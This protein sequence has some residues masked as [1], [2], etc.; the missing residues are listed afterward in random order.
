M[1]LK[2]CKLV[3]VTLLTPITAFAHEFWIEPLSY[4][5][6]TGATVSAHLNVGQNFSG[7]TYSYIEDNFERFDLVDRNGA[8]TPV[9]G[10]LGDRPALNMAPPD[11]G[12][13]IIV[14]ETTDNW[15]NYSDWKKFVAFVEHKAFAGALE[16]HQANG[17]PLTGFAETYR[18]FAKS[19]VAVGD[20]QGQD[21]AVGL[22]TEIVALQ[23]PYRADPS[24]GISVQVLYKGTPRIEAQVEVFDKSPDG[25][26]TVTTTTTDDKGIATIPVSSGHSYLIDAVILRETG[27]ATP[28]DGPIWHSLWASLTFAIPG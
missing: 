27:N 3:L 6:D 28:A 11:T 23:N 10:R 21:R 19:L 22:E 20:G 18:R 13:V 25:S 8:A 9:E 1:M 26:V 7:S 5:I 15:L 16:A 17:W 12:L 4:Q 24:N 14:H 2:I